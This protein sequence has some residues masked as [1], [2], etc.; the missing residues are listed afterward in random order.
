MLGISEDI[1]HKLCVENEF[2]DPTFNFTRNAYHT[3]QTL[4]E[5]YFNN[6]TNGNYTEAFMKITGLD[7]N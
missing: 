6:D 2:N 5:I 4:V 1:S 7:Y 3:S